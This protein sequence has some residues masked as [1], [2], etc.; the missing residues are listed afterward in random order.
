MSKYS[1]KIFKFFLF[2]HKI[3]DIKE[4]K[5]KLIICHHNEKI[6]MTTRW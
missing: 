3:T 1:E 6:L 5:I 2:W 4:D